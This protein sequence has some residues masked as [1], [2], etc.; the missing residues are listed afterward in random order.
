[1]HGS[2]IVRCQGKDRI[3]GR[4]AAWLDPDLRPLVRVGR[5]AAVV[6]E[7][8]AALQICVAQELV[9]VERRRL[10]D[11]AGIE[12]FGAAA[13]EAVPARVDCG[14]ATASRS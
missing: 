9:G 12:Q 13:D 5:R 2:G 6:D 10:E 1:L 11:A 4:R 3:L 7:V 14:R 8:A